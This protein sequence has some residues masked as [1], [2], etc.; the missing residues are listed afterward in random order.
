MLQSIWNYKIQVLPVLLALLLTELPNIIRKYK[1]LY[2]IPIYFSIF[3]LRELNSDL[4]VYLGEDYF[5]G[6]GASLGKEELDRIKRKIM[7]DSAVSILI[8]AL[9]IPVVAGFV[10]S[11]FLNRDLLLQS[12]I[13]VF[14]YKLIN[15]CKAVVDFK[16]HAVGSRKN[17]FLLILV[18]IG[19][20]GVFFQLLNN[21]YDWAR[22]FVEI[23]NYKGLLSALSDLIFNKAIAQGLVL[24]ALAAFFGNMITDKAIR[25]ENINN[26]Q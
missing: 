9:L 8:S 12:I 2:Y 10:L 14:I 18:Y 3:P 17:I 15:I 4:A 22:P 6:T 1:K 25:D 16:D 21:S 7:V 20:L 11:F 19:Y 13:V 5:V 23:N 26:G 24:A